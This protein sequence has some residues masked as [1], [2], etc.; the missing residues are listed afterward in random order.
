VTEVMRGD[1]DSDAVSD[2]SF[3]DS[4]NEGD[5]AVTRGKQ[6]GVGAARARKGDGGGSAGEESGEN[7]GDGG[8]DAGDDGVSD[9]DDRRVQ[10]RR[11]AKGL[12]P[13]KIVAGRLFCEVCPKKFFVKT[14][15]YLA[16]CQGKVRGSVSLRV[17]LSRCHA[18]AAASRRRLC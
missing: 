1:V 15:D 14:D 11:D 18:V 3:T 17:E 6:R 9:D 8:D 5:G 7:E 4:E 10:V 16:H 2:A 12:V 13:G